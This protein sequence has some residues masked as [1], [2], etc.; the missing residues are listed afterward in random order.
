MAKLPVYTRGVAPQFGRAAGTSISGREGQALQQFA[1]GASSLYQANQEIERRSAS[2]YALEQKNASQVAYAEKQVELSQTATNG[3]EYITGMSEFLMAERQRAVE[4]APNQQAAKMVTD[5]YGQFEASS[6]VA[7]INQAAKINAENSARAVE[8]SIELAKTSTFLNPN[9]YEASVQNASEAIMMSDL[10]D[11]QK[12]YFI[13]KTT[14]DIYR[15]KMLGEIRQDPFSAVVTLSQGQGEL[16]AAEHERMFNSA[17]R[18][19]DQAERELISKQARIDKEVQAMQGQIESSTARDGD[20]LLANNQLNYGWITTNRDNLSD[21]DYRYFLNKLD[22][23]GKRPE[24]NREI[25][26]D[27][28]EK[29]GDGENVLQEARDHYVQGDLTQADYKAITGRFEQSDELPSAYKQGEQYLRDNFRPSELNPSIGSQSRYANVTTEWRD[30]FARNP[31][32]TVTDAMT[33]ARS[34]EKRY[35]TV[36][37][38]E[39]TYLFLAGPQPMFLEG[40]RTRYRTGEAQMSEIQQTA[41]ETYR[42]YTEGRISEEVYRREQQLIVEWSKLLQ[43]AQATRAQVETKQ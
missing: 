17:I 8:K 28:Y 18:A 16:D 9:S 24:T 19:K 34:I 4:N 7:A 15:S 6:K 12:D 22:G 2:T 31:N 29:A 43:E 40:S 30:W 23:T 21:S 38:D 41:Q 14:Q 13:K 3:E 33:E 39:T 26:V 32:A 27:L 35:R 10:P 36:E 37:L 5:Y 42:A 1:A 25:Y 20:E 11:N